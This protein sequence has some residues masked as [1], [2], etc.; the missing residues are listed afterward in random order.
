[1]GASSWGN[2]FVWQSWEN[3]A[4]DFWGKVLSASGVK[5][6]GATHDLKMVR[7]IRGGEGYAYVEAGCRMVGVGVRFQIFP[8]AQSGPWLS[9]MPSSLNRAIDAYVATIVSRR[10]HP[11]LKGGFPL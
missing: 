1:M 5:A 9:P 6:L 2:L 3:A 7:A 11:L 4:L 8:F 10:M